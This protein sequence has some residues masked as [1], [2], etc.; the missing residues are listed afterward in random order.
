VSLPYQ[1]P[2]LTL[3][4]GAD[5]DAA[6]VRALQRDLR[7]LGYLGHGID[8]DFGL[9]TERAVRCLQFDLLNNNGA[10]SAEDGPAPVAIR[11]FNRQQGNTR[12]VPAVTGQLDQGTALC[13][14][15]LLSSDAVLKLPRSNDPVAD[16][17]RAMDAVENTASDVAPTPFI[18]AM[19]IQESSSHHFEVPHGSDEDSYVSI[20][21]DRND[22]TTQDHITSRG[23][24]L[25]QCTIY[26]H[27]PRPDELSAFIIDPV[28][29]VHFA[30]DELRGK[31]DKFVVGPTDR[32]DDRSAE[33]PSLPLRL[34]VYQ[35]TDPRYMLD[36]RNC[37]ART[38]KMDI[39]RGTPVHEGAALSYQPTQ[40]YPSAEYRGVPNRAE[41]P[42]DWPY[43][44]RR[45]NGSGV[46]SYH[47]QTR[48]LLNLLSLPPRTGS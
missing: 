26:H 30:Y 23:Y 39:T 41:I 2:G 6:L 48:I 24:G 42:C 29:N 32:A 5:N 33:H 12:P 19:V 15:A 8:G 27:P 36:C 40:Y 38:H 10:S 46:N 18:A 47:Y 28:Q 3:A 13:I 4:H 17:A 21:L 1:K 22:Q 45:Y 44:A 25:G 43:A 31:F 35:R 9:R 7:A 34:C 11:D 14:E 37:A 16:N 20:G